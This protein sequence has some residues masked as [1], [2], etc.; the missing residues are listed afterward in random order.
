M[1]TKFLTTAIVVALSGLTMLTPGG[2]SESRGP[3][4]D[5]LKRLA[6][7]WVR[8]D[9][10]GAMTDQVISQIRVTAGGSAV[11]SES[12]IPTNSS[13]TRTTK[14]ASGPAIPMSNRAFFRRIGALIL[15]K[16]PRVPK[17][18]GNGRKSI[19]PP[20][21]PRRRRFSFWTNRPLFWIP[22]TNRTFTDYWPLSI[23]NG[24]SRLSR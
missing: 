14:P 15:M 7:E 18:A 10:N 6:G 16:A 4:L 2:E 17:A 1:L 5:T 23:V 11:G 13:G 21:W 19:S 8:V 20:H 12:A 3:S 24:E 22:S 9:E